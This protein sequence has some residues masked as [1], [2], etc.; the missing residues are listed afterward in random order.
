MIPVVCRKADMLSED[1]GRKKRQELRIKMISRTIK[2]DTEVAG[3]DKF[4]FI[5][6]ANDRNSLVTKEC[7]HRQNTQTRKEEDK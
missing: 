1:E 7:Y 6:A 4:T 3:Y 5:V 2:M